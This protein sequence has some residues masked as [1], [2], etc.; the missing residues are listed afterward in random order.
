MILSHPWSNVDRSS[1]PCML[2]QPE[3]AVYINVHLN[4]NLYKK[5]NGSLVK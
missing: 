2:Y 4:Q 3:P 1:Q 5:K